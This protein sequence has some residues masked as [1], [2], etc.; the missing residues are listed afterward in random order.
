MNWSSNIVVWQRISTQDQITSLT[1]CE[2][3]VISNEMPSFNGFH[4]L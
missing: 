4:A 2:T 1:W 3:N